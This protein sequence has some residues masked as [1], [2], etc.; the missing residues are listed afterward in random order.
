MDTNNWLGQ[1]QRPN[2]LATP[3]QTTSYTLTANRLGCAAQETVTVTVTPIAI[4]ILSLDTIPICKGVSVPLTATA[5]PIGTTITWTPNNGSLNTTTGPNV[6]A[7]PQTATSYVASVSTAGCV[8]F[9]TVYIGVDSLPWNMLIL[10]ADTVIC[11]GEKVLLTSLVYEPGDF[12]QIEFLWTPSF[13]QLTPDSFYNMVVQPVETTTYYRTA[14]NGFCSATDSATVTVISVT[15]MEITPDQPVICQGDTVQLTATSPVPLEYSWEPTDGLSCTDCP[16]PVASPSQSITYMVTGEYQG[17]PIGGSVS[18]EVVVPPSINPVQEPLCPGSSTGL[19]LAANGNWS[20]VWTSPDDP[21]FNSTEP[22]PIVS[23]N[24]TTNYVVTVDN[25][26]CPPETFEMTLFV[27]DNPMLNL[28]PDTILC[29][30]NSI[31]L[32]AYAGEPGGTYTWST[33]VTGPNPTVNLLLGVNNFSV[34][35]TNSCGDSLTGTVIVE[36]APGI[37]VEILPTDTNTYYQGTVLNLSTTTTQPAVSYQWSNGSTTDTTNFVML[38]LPSEAIFVTVTDDL[39]C[40]DV[41]SL[42]FSVLESMFAIPNAFS[43]NGDSKN[44]R[45]KVVILGENVEV[46]SM[47]IW[48]RWGQLVFEEKNSNEGWDGLQKGEPAA[49]DVYVFRAVIT[50]PDGTR[51]VKSGDM[52]LLR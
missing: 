49:S 39:G 2:P 6:V 5:I 25:G 20:Y 17:C 1:R 9:D 27:S 16:N 48:N 40:T 23:P 24:Q 18:V 38:N 11:L 35:Y 22:N 19:N 42:T 32:S 31:Q 44:D 51:S 46:V 12:G 47:S 33:G 14:T 34:V 52:T 4:D 7:T 10:P 26:V 28:S 8:R 45:F 3:T 29:S 43:P 30:V 50:R 13:G 15:S 37:D 21:N 41:D 36:L